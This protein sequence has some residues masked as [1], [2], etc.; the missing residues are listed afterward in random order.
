MSDHSSSKNSKIHNNL[1]KFKERNINYF[2]KSLLRIYF[3][4][5]SVFF[6]TYFI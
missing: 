2:D 1:T 3:Q 4:L 6:K 5:L